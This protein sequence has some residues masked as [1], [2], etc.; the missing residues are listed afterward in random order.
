M[1]KDVQGFIIKKKVRYQYIENKNCSQ[2]NFYHMLIMPLRFNKAENVA[3]SLQCL[4]NV[5][6]WETPLPESA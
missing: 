1:V 6:L 3:K 2:G 4:K 5:I